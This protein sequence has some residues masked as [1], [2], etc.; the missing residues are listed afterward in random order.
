MD[1]VIEQVNAL[2]LFGRSAGRPAGLDAVCR[3]LPPGHALFPPDEQ[4]SQA[5]TPAAIT[6]FR[7]LYDLFLDKT[8]SIPALISNKAETLEE[9]QH[10]SI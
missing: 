7:L 9:A 2:F 8:S 5:A 10:E 6:T 1:G 3:Q 4:S